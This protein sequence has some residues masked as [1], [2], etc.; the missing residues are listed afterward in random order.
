MDGVDV[1]AELQALNASYRALETVVAVQ[2]DTIAAMNA[3]A[4]AAAEQHSAST[5]TVAGVNVQPYDYVS[6]NLVIDFT[7]G[8]SADLNEE[9]LTTKKIIVGNLNIKGTS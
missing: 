4:A 3:S 8:Y 7:P 1:V 5:G 2:R 6:G 9:F